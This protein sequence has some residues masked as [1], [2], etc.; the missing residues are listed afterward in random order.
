MLR[1]LCLA[2]SLAASSTCLVLPPTATKL[3]P[4]ARG[5]YKPKPKC[6][7]RRRLKR[8]MRPVMTTD[9][10][11]SDETFS[12]DEPR[13][14]RTARKAPAKMSVDRSIPLPPMSMGNIHPTGV[15]LDAFLDTQLIDPT[16]APEEC[17]LSKPAAC[18]PG[19]EN[20]KKLVREDYYMAEALWAGLFC[21]LGVTIGMQAV[22]AVI[23]GQATPEPAGDLIVS[24]AMCAFIATQP[25]LDSA[26]GYFLNPAAAAAAVDVATAAASSCP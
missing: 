11:E 19:L 8:F 24:P 26:T 3:V 6:E 21:S 10:S 1:L 25:A 9:N 7:K 16:S 12:S 13:K 4:V 14:S 15:D 2:A 17:D 20:F 23:A 18:I 22:R 5:A